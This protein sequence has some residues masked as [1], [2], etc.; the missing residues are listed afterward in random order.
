MIFLILIFAGIYT[1]T[2]GIE[3]DMGTSQGFLSSLYFSA[4]TQTT[5]GY[6]DLNP[7]GFTKG[8]MAVQAVLGTIYSV[9]FLGIIVAKLLWPP[10]S[11]E[12]S[13]IAVFDYV[14]Q[15]FRFRFYNTHKLPLCDTRYTI[16]IRGV[17]TTGEEY[18]YRNF[19]I[20][21]EYPGHPIIE[22]TKPWVVNTKPCNGMTINNTNNPDPTKENIL[23][24]EQ[25]RENTLIT[26]Q[27]EGYYPGIGGQRSS[28]VKRIAVGNIKCGRLSF[29][30]KIDPSGDV[31]ITNWDNFDKY[32]PVDIKTCQS[33]IRNGDCFLAKR[34]Y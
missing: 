15:K 11:I 33:C 9:L 3:D 29:V 4:I 23:L 25:L 21:I 10:H 27:I 14:E 1:A 24:P 34:L 6:G 20:E 12:I 8:I 16:S 22:S 28:V 31:R 2:S 26:L 18:I 32:E 5:V 19:R 30:Q 17:G 7:V 13:D